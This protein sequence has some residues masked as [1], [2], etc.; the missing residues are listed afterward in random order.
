MKIIRIVTILLC[1]ASLFSCTPHNPP[2]VPPDHPNIVFILTDD[3]TMAD[4]A[5]MPKTKNLIGENGA[6]FTHFFVSFSLCCPSR[7]SILRGQY[8]H[9]TKI[10]D[11]ELPN[12]GFEKAYAMGLETS[13]LPVWLQQAGYQT[14]LFGKYLN[15]YPDQAGQT[16]IPPG[17]TEWY[18]PAAGNPYSEFNYSLNE[19]GKLVAYGSAPSDYGTDVYAGKAVDFIKRSAAQGKPFFAYVS[20]YAPHKPATPAPRH[21]ASFATTELPRPPSFNEPDMR[22]KLK[23]FLWKPLLD[24]KQIKQLEELYRLRLESLQAVDE[25]VANIV[26]TLQATDQFDN[27]YIFFTS[28]NGFHLGQHRLPAG[29]NTPYEEDILVPLLISGPGIKAGLKIDALAGNIDIAPTI[30]TLAGATAP[31]YVDGRSI[32]PLLSGNTIPD[33]RK[34]YLL[35]RNPANMEESSTLHA[36]ISHQP[37]PDWLAGLLEPPDSYFDKQ[38]GIYRGLRTDQYTY[39]EFSNGVSQIYDLKKDP[40]EIENFA[41][42]ADPALLAKYHKWLSELET[43]TGASCRK[44]DV[45]P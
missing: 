16:Y 31:D 11:N 26:S 28:D 6:S 24:E 5:Y 7:A 20:T 10:L 22:D 9:N 36:N 43:C 13:M 15:G 40:Y 41:A 37:K 23:T 34:A 39:V 25:M 44:Y 4:L 14:A 32:T 8:A 29:K 42:T 1:C 2:F 17:W 38:P 45:A 33:W 30:A 21:V 12:G 27:T 3:M 19:N 18:S 35:E